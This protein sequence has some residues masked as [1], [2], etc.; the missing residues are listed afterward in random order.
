M[1]YPQQIIGYC[2]DMLFPVRCI[3]CLVFSDENKH[4]YLCGSC[5]K[6]INIKK[7][8][9]C[10]GCKIKSPFGKTCIEC[11]DSISIDNL[12]IVSDYNNLLLEKMLKLFKYRF[13]TEVADSLKPLIKQ[14]IFYLNKDR[15]LNIIEDNPIIIP[16]PLHPRRLNWRG[17]N[18]AEILAKILSDIIQI[19]NIKL[20]IR[21]KFSRPQVEIGEREA[22]LNNTRDQ[23]KL[24]SPDKIKNRTIILIDDICTTGATLNEAARILKNNGAKKVIGFVIARG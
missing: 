20:L 5:L 1:N 19:D 13:I 7:N 14:Y 18:Q 3:N 24:I 2:L 4:Q 23:F 8:M 22:R 9:E 6:S 17:F 16:I 15:R 21:T 12:L 10:I 11:R